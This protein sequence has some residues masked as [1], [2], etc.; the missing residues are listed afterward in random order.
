MMSLL[1]RTERLRSGAG[2][3]L[4][5]AGALGVVALGIAMLMG[6]IGKM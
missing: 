1:A 4:E 6:R 2:W 3:G 5:M